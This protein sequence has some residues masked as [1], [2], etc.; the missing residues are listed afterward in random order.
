MLLGAGAMLAGYTGLT[1]SLLVIMLETTES[2]DIFLPMMVTIMVSRAVS[3]L[4]TRSL[5]DR[6]LRTK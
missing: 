5:Y 6:A 4:F 3:K 1:Y 2:I